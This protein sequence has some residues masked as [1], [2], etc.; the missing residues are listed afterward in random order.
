MAGDVG[1]GVK[2]VIRSTQPLRRDWTIERVEG[3]PVIRSR[4][5]WPVGIKLRALSLVELAKGLGED[6][7]WLHRQLCQGLQLSR[8]FRGADYGTIE[9]HEGVIL[10]IYRGHTIYTIQEV[11]TVK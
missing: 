8:K 1:S 3:A 9:L 4:A 7:E 10:V 11:G 5:N 6:T 2:P